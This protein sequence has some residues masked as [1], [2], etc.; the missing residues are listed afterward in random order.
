MKIS[1]AIEEFLEA[2]YK[3]QKENGVAK[4]TRLAKELNVALGTVTNTVEKMER[5]NLIVH[6]VYK[7]VKLTKK[8]EALALSVIRRHR[9]S[10]RL[11]TD[12]LSVNWD[13]AHEKACLLEHGLSDEVA[14]LI[15]KRLNY[16]KTCPHGNPIPTQDG[17]IEKEKELTLLTEL[18][19][20]EKFT[21]VKITEERS[22]LLKHLKK[23]NL[24]P[25]SSAK[26]KSSLPLNNLILI[27][28][29][30][31]SCCLTQQAASKIWVKK[32]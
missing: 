23:H 3:L 27:N 26:I 12:F 17:Q 1:S 7:G 32:L 18:K 19:P 31:E 6:T 16:P 30:D 4:T 8:G 24:T 22:E 11:L 14:S 15:E 20:Q 2:I 25:G 10:E 5:K 21:I 28:V 29:N 13:E 9:L